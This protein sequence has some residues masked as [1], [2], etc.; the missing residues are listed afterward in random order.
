MD[1]IK[2]PGDCSKNCHTIRGKHIVFHEG[3][4]NFGWCVNFVSTLVRLAES[5]LKIR[6]RK[7]VFVTFKYR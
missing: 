2:S 5:G 4:S 6:A 3:V 1:D 7:L